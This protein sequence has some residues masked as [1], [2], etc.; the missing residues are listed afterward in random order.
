MSASIF[1]LCMNLKLHEGL[2][3]KHIGL[4]LDLTVNFHLLFNDVTHLC[5]RLLVMSYIYVLVY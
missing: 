5:A 4:V 3:H 2:P 1:K